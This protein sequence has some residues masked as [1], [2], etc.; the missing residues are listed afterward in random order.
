V[1]VG[2]PIA[3]VLRYR[4]LDRKWHLRLGLVFAVLFLI[5]AF[6]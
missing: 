2:V 4:R 3:G 1:L 6:L 5:H